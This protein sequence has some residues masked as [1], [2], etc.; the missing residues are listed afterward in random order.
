VVKHLSPPN[1]AAAPV[2]ANLGERRRAYLYKLMS[3]KDESK[4]ARLHTDPAFRPNCNPI[5]DG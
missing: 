2:R 1:G 3:Y 5:K 4:W